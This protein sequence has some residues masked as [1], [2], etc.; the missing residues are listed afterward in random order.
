M[1]LVIGCFCQEGSSSSRPHSTC[2]RHKIGQSRRKPTESTKLEVDRREVII[3]SRTG[4]LR[5]TLFGF[6]D[7]KLGTSL[8]GPGKV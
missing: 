2:R 5:D 6:S 7:P 3:I 8:T 1:L 4:V